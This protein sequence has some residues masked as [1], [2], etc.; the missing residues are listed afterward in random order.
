M[1]METFTI[2][3]VI[4]IVASKYSGV[5]SSSAI[6]L[7]LGL[8]SLLISSMSCGVSEKYATSEA[9]TKADTYNKTK[10]HRRAT[11]ALS[12]IGC[13]KTSDNKGIESKITK[14]RETCQLSILCRYKCTYFSAH[15]QQETDRIFAL[16]TT[17]KCKILFP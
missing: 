4:K 6:F 7:F 9:D 1:M 13:T 17:S 2:L 16:H 11:I 14:F 5:C 8:S 10:I 12:E 3:L 15:V